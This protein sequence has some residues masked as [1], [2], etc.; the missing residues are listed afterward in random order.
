LAAVNELVVWITPWTQLP[1]L[2]Q[3]EQ[4]AVLLREAT[5][6]KPAVRLLVP[7][8]YGPWVESQ[9]NHTLP[10]D[11]VVSNPAD[12]AALRKQV[13]AHGFR[14]GVW[15]VPHRS[16]GGTLAGQLAHAAGYYVGNFEIGEFWIHGQID[17]APVT[18]Y[19]T[20]YWNAAGQ[21]LDGKTFATLVP[22]DGELAAY[23]TG[24][25]MVLREIAGGCSGM[26]LETYGGPNTPEYHWPNLWPMHSVERVQRLLP[27]V[28]LLTMPA[29][30]NLADQWAFGVW[31][32]QH[33]VHTWCI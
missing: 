26:V 31:Q 12:V 23:Q 4:V 14:F 2:H 18:T 11:L 1:S 15:G 24:G 25:F 19:W 32:G 17:P 9:C 6:M 20:D 27:E 13:E 7:V 5:G 29:D 30:E 3:A 22:S 33:V 21:D 8:H 16:D 10:P 28:R